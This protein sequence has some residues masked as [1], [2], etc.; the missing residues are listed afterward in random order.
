[1][2]LQDLRAKVSNSSDDKSKL[3]AQQDL[4][5]ALEHRLNKFESTAKEMIKETDDADP[6]YT[7]HT[8]ILYDYVESF[9][10]I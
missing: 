9:R 5:F 10:N 1:M 7:D 2:T 6:D 4:I 3:Q 8:A